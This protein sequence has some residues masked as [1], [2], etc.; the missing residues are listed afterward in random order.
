MQW[1]C[2]QCGNLLRKGEL[3]CRHCGTALALPPAM[4]AQWEASAG[5]TS[6]TVGWV[7]AVVLIGGIL[8]GGGL[9]LTKA[10][11]NAGTQM[12]YAT[13]IE[14]FNKAA[15]LYAAKNYEAAAPAF[16]RVAQNK[17]NTDEILKKATDG[18]VWSYR[19]L[20]HAA[21][22][23]SDWA[24]AQRWY[25]KA[26]DLKPDDTAAKS[27]Y[28]AVT[29]I[30]NS[31]A[32]AGPSNVVPPADRTM[33]HPTA[34]RTG[35]PNLKAAD[36]ERA[37]AQTAQEAQSLL[38]QANDAY[39]AGNIN[40]ALQLWSKVV[41]KAPGSAAATEAQNYPHAVRPRQQPF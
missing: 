6:R 24:T 1:A 4:Q 21:Q 12:G 39:R 32:P 40:Q 26:L 5:S 18:G 14:D 16:E 3:Q 38:S 33:Q 31:T 15:A 10:F 7:L 25:K 29:R 37:Q 19:E 27:E 20:G 22:A 9:A 2:P 11:K 8:G 28:D 36:F 35:T 41:G 34:P 13:G 23:K 30:L 17:T